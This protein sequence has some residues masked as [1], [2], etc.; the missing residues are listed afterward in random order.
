MRTTNGSA[1]SMD[2]TALWTR[3]ETVVTFALSELTRA[4]RS[5][6]PVL[7]ASSTAE[8]SSGSAAA[9]G[10][11]SR[12]SPTMYSKTVILLVMSFVSSIFLRASSSKPS[13]WPR[14]VFPLR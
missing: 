1:G 4:S 10:N 13:A 11:L 14:A 6:S 2:S 7:R 12:T 5:W 8:S 9:A 3:S